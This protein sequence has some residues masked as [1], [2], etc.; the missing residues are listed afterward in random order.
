MRN[1]LLL[2]LVTTC[3]FTSFSIKA[4]SEIDYRITL[5]DGRQIDLTDT[6]TRRDLEAFSLYDLR[7]I[8]NAYYAKHLYIFQSD[9]LTYAFL[10]YEWYLPLNPDVSTFLGSMDKQNIQKVQKAEDRLRNAIKRNKDNPLASQ[11]IGVWH[12]LPFMPAGFADAYQFF[13][14]GVFIKNFNQMDCSKRVLA[15]VGTWEINENDSIKLT[16]NAKREIVGGEY[17]PAAGS[18]VGEKELVGG[19]IVENHISKPSSIWYLSFEDYNLHDQY[20][21]L[22]I[23]LEKTYFKY[24][25]NP[26]DYY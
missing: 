9:E 13:K 21:T 15:Y 12:E 18:C 4:Y 19:E 16:I 25:G 17:M 3:F 14:D 1:A 26:K 11:I 22:K 8:R 10:P 7:I 23:E 20:S 2:L 5:K 24:S 6:L